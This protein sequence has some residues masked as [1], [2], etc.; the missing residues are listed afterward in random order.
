MLSL[1]KLFIIFIFFIYTESQIGSFMMMPFKTFNNEGELIS[2]NKLK[3]WFEDIEKRGFK[4]ITLDFWW[5]FTEPYPNEYN[6]LQYHKLMNILKEYNLKIK[7]ILSF[8]QCGSTI[9]DECWIQLPEWILNSD[10]KIFYK[11][12]KN[13]IN[14]EYISV[15]ADKEILSDGRTV[16]QAYSEYI[17]QFNNEFSK[18]YGTK[19]ID[20]E[21]GTGPAGQLHYPSYSYKDAFCGVGRFQGSSE[22]AVNQFKKFLTDIK[23]KQS[24]T[25][26]LKLDY[27]GTPIIEKEN[28][29]PYQEWFFKEIN[30]EKE[31][32]NAITRNKI[33][34]GNYYTKENECLEKGCCWKEEPGSPYCYYKENK[35]VN[36]KSN[37]GKLWTYWYQEQQLIHLQKLLLIARK[38]LNILIPLSVKL[39]CV[40]WLAGDN[41]RAAELT[42]GFLTNKSNSEFEQSEADIKINYNK[43]KN[44]VENVEELDYKQFLFDSIFSVNDLTFGKTIKF[45]DSYNSYN[46]IFKLVKNFRAKIVFSCVEL[47]KEDFP[48]VCNSAPEKLMAEFK[49]NSSVYNIPI[50]AENTQK[51]IKEEME[52][53]LEKIRNNLPGFFQF[54]Y[55]RMDDAENNNDNEEMLQISTQK[56][57]IK[58]LIQLLD[59]N[60]PSNYYK[61]KK[62]IL[63]ET[64]ECRKCANDLDHFKKILRVI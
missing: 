22:L 54:N 23:Y 15:F 28:H 16:L 27:I 41:T 50:I 2:V 59:S 1:K 49:Q 62:I 36:Y 21:L 51:L 37:Y 17:Q 13:N 12:N 53:K 47:A 10:Q 34:C 31:E 43:I 29:K 11:D 42:S 8:H 39:P 57:V 25:K 60:K 18:Y 61:R 19:I 55:M 30:I 45:I 38:H 46:Q 9:G 26:N 14:K 7:P 24:N 56:S 20:I 4:G 5:R 48:N 35:V 64:I 33:D 32:C 44:L 52:N 63:L 58:Q 40:H 6:F 3:A